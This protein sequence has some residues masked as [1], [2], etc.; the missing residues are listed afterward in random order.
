MNREEYT[1]NELT[2]ANAEIAELC[3]YP[4][5][6]Q[7]VQKKYSVHNKKRKVGN[8]VLIRKNAN[9]YIHMQPS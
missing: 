3:G 9:N 2:I 1:C 6:L 5:V 8:R 7:K 4:K